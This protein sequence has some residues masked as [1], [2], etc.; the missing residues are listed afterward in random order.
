MPEILEKTDAE[1]TRSCERINAWLDDLINQL[2]EDIVKTDDPRAQA[3]FETTAE[4]LVGLK[5]AYVHFEAGVEPAFKRES[6]EKKGVIVSPTPPQGRASS[7]PGDAGP[8]SL[9]EA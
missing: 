7:P 1:T 3:L 9:G 8:A 5:T 2:R 6:I 4:V